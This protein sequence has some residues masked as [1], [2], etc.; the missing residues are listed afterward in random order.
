MSI[1]TLAHRVLL[2]VLLLS[3]VSLSAAQ[4]QAAP[5]SSIRGKVLD[6][7]SGAEIS[8]VQ[9]TSTPI[10]SPVA[11]AADGAFSVGNLP[12]GR[13]VL[14]FKA[15]GYIPQ[16]VTYTLTPGEILN[17][18][19]VLLSPT[20][21]VSGKVFRSSGEPAVGV[22]VI[23]LGY[24]AANGGRELVRSA[25]VR[26][27]DR[28]EFRLFDIVPGKYRLAFGWGSPEQVPRTINPVF[29]TMYPHG[30]E[31]S[32]G[33][34]IELQAGAD[35]KLSDTTLETDQ[36]SWRLHFINP[37]PSDKDVALQIGD[38]TPNLPR[39]FGGG[40]FFPPIRFRIKAGET[41]T[42]TIWPGVFGTYSLITSWA[43]VDRTP[44]WL[45]TPLE[46]DGKTTDTDILLTEPTGQLRVHAVKRE[47]DGKVSPLSSARIGICRAKTPACVSPAFWVDRLVDRGGG[48]FLTL[49]SSV[50]SLGVDGSLTF[51][52]LI[53]GEF[54]LYSLA[55]PDGH[56]LARA[57][58]GEKN[59]LLE[60][61]SVSAKSPTLEVEVRA[62]AGTVQGKVTNKTGG[63]VANALVALVA[64]GPLEVSK[65]QVLRRAIVTDQDGTFEIRNLIPTNYRAYAWE[66]VPSDAYMDEVFLA[67]YRDA[68]ASITIP[69]RADLELKI[70]NER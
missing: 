1:A 48:V 40:T 38:Q 50:I 58:Q 2:P 3:I 34:E 63:A 8:R 17:A 20:A 45:L 44:Q 7:G 29:P 13:V 5:P 4:R 26:A 19:P 39:G 18:K 15:D 30:R 65:L 25:I 21:A 28:G 12:P 52:P 66:S 61:I 47:S 23:L 70:L 14:T 56:Y 37:G 57:S 46:Y 32:Q 41:I 27:N 67:S 69:T 35:M 10:N 51:P 54:E 9:V 42:R 36:G 31:I 33:E 53:P 62:N 49:P 43:N 60:G 6:D 11:T 64:D 24:R 55:V 59:I 16:S 68:A 22:D